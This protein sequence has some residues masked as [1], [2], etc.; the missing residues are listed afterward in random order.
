VE[1]PIRLAAGSDI[2]DDA[3]FVPLHVPGPTH[4]TFGQTVIEP[5][6]RIMPWLAVNPTMKPD[7]Q[8]WRPSSAWVLAAVSTPIL[9][10]G[11]LAVIGYR[12]GELRT[13]LGGTPSGPAFI[14]LLALAVL[15]AGLAAAAERDLWPAV[16]VGVTGLL[17][18]PWLGLFGRTASEGG[19]VVEFMAAAVVLLLGIVSVAIGQLAVTN[20]QAVQHWL[21][22]RSRRLGAAAGTATFLLVV[23][24]RNVVWGAPAWSLTG[25]GGLL[26][27]WSAVGL[28]LLGAVPAVLLVRLRLVTPAVVVVGLL[29]AAT[30]LTLSS[31]TPEYAAA[32]GSPL[33]YYAVGWF[34]PLALGLLAAGIEYRVRSGQGRHPVHGDSHIE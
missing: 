10:T 16:A 14:Y 13:L 1:E 17:V 26:W 28:V 32:A 18:L 15:G 29:A 34:V 33:T 22:P 27:L 4:S 12:L 21:T 25:F 11:Y 2:T 9:V 31:P 8:P 30:A 5:S 24:L 3:P 7:A 19:S 23:L 20:R 6:I